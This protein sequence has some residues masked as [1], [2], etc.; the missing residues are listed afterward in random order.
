MFSKKIIIQLSAITAVVLSPAVVLAGTFD[1]VMVGFK[2]LGTAA[3]FKTGESGE[4]AIE[5][6]YAFSNYINGMLGLMG[7][8]FFIQ[9]AYAGYLWLT[10]RGNEEQVKKA[11]DKMINSV[12]A[13]AIIIAARLIVEF[14]LF[15]LG[16]L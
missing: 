14:A 15:V 3:G 5:F 1:Q 13:L 4:P 10:A 12:I 11:K 8:L 9:T 6:V 2:G 7:A 16:Q